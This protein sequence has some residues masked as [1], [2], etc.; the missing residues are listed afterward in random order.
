MTR[1]CHITSVECN[2]VVLWAK[3]GVSF[4]VFIMFLIFNLD[5]NYDNIQ[6][7]LVLIKLFLVHERDFVAR[8][9]F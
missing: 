1:R 5:R 9:D 3:C 6:L 4:S 7:S 8:A 2:L